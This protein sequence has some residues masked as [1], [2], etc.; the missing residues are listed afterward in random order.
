MCNS[1]LEACWT[2]FSTL[3]KPHSAIVVARLDTKQ[4]CPGRWNNSVTMTIQGKKNKEC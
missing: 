4:G 3:A 2:R 1:S